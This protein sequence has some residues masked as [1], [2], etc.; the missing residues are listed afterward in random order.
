MKQERHDALATPTDRLWRIARR[1]F[2]ATLAAARVAGV[3]HI[4]AAIRCENVGGLAY[5]DG[6]GFVDYR[7]GHGAISKRRDLA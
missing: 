6:M 4:D 7:Q 3:H 5:Y 2:E 1:L